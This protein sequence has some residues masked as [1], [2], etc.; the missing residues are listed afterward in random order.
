MPPPKPTGQSQPPTREIAP[1]DFSRSSWRDSPNMASRELYNSHSGRYEPVGDRRGSFRSGGEVHSRPPAVLQ[2]PH[3]NDY[4]PE[5]SPSF[6]TS[7]QG[8]EAPFGRRRGSSNVSG[9]SG[10]LQRIGKGYEP[11]PMGP[12]ELL[13]TRR[14][15]FTG[16]TD[17]PVSP[18]NYS[19]SGQHGGRLQ[20]GHAWPNRTSP[21]M[22]HATPNY[23]STPP[24][25]RPPSGTNAST[26]EPSVEY[27]KRLMREK[28]EEAMKRRLEEEKR[29]EA[30][31]QE[32]IRL[33][34]AAMGPAPER[35][36]ARK[37]GSGK[38]EIATTHETTHSGQT[39]GIGEDGSKEGLDGLTTS[40]SLEANSSGSTTGSQPGVAGHPRPA[41]PADLKQSNPWDSSGASSTSQ[42]RFPVWPSSGQQGLRNVW[43]SPNNDRGLGNGTFNP[44]L[45][46]VP[47]SHPAAMSQTPSK[48]PSPIAPP[49]QARSTGRGQPVP[50]AAPAAATAPGQSYSQS[51]GDDYAAS[52]GQR[53]Y[54]ETQKGWVNTVL[55]SDNAIREQQLKERVELDRRLAEQGLTY[56]Q[57]QPTIKHT[58]RQERVTQLEPRP[59][60]V[61]PASIG[62]KESTS[63]APNGVA[64]PPPPPHV[65]SVPSA[66]AGSPSSILPP[67]GAA[68]SSQPR[69]SRFFPSKDVRH[70][71]Q[72]PAD[73]DRSPSPPPPTM[74]GHPVYDGDVAHPHV[75]LPRPQ[76]IV[77]LP[78]APVQPAATQTSTS[79]AAHNSKKGDS[80]FAWASPAPYRGASSA[81][82][83][84]THLQQTSPPGHS[85]GG[86]QSHLAM[87]TNSTPHSQQEWQEKIYEL[88]GRR[89]GP[90][91][92]PAVESA[93]KRALDY[94]VRSV[95]A[96]VSLPGGS[97]AVKDPGDVM[98]KPM[99]DE[100]FEE[101]E[102][103]SL[104]PVCIPH[105]A[106]EAGWQPAMAPKPL[107][108]KFL[109]TDA[110]S[111]DIFELAAASSVICVYL[112]AIGHREPRAVPWSKTST[113]GSYRGSGHARAA[114]P[115]PRG[116]RGGLRDGKRESSNPFPT[117]TAGNSTPGSLSSTSR[118]RGGYRGGRPG[119]S[120]WSRRSGQASNV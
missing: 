102:M 14:G 35:R 52:P 41:G 82:T 96:T 30:A 15:S 63:A 70:G 5:P 54:G 72:M 67:K 85:V 90:P 50:T 16:S 20:T 28:A 80:T 59:K 100:C 8:P 9:G 107:P 48:G 79:A 73:H 43:G 45:G 29:E 39:G 10:Y 51:R 55:H 42:D 74:S 98:T 95:S 26:D 18:R 113:R 46:R 7:R 31:K 97:G 1:D 101:Q 114:G 77:K 44:D 111:T 94:S 34:L 87:P 57:A 25:V 61:R 69:P 68:T 83:T 23:G 71:S 112:P 93:S 104:P 38:D 110:T 32:R 49:S 103:G 4:A 66:P 6:Q 88:T 53:A 99:A 81:A 22:M 64:G 17:S 78:P 75:S 109:L 65:T 120:E 91:K 33:K 58:W 76:P 119:G 24:D 86:P 108:R 117:E 36:S 11:T 47:D 2:R 12:P 27:Q 118:G 105:K 13:G 19:P 116:V 40:S 60:G 84:P 106:P 21:S 92:S 89:G 115:R 37:D 3:H 62:S 56:E